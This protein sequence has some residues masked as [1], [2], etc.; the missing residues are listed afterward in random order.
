M[1]NLTI[2]GCCLKNERNQKKYGGY[3]KRCNS[4]MANIN[5]KKRRGVDEN[6]LAKSADD[7]TIIELILAGKSTASIAAEIARKEH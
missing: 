2:C 6:T 4:L 3:C 7:V 5:Q 1:E